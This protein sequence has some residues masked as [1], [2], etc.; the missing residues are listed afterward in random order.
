METQPKE[1]NMDLDRLKKEFEQRPVEV[2]AVA[3][4]AVLALSKVG[5]T[6]ASMRSKNAYAKMAKRALKKK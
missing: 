3:T 6:L 1:D 2:I 4:A 5:E